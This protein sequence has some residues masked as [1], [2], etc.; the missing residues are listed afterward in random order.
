MATQQK[1]NGNGDMR[2]IR[3]GF[4]IFLASES[5]VIVTL[6]A[7]RFLTAGGNVGPYSQ[8]L[9]AIT[10]LFMLISGFA[11]RSGRTAITRGDNSAMQRRLKTGVWFGVLTVASVLLQWILFAHEGVAVTQPA[12]EAYYVLTGIWMLIALVSGFALYAAPIRGRRIGGY[13]T[14]NH[15]DVDAATYF[16][17][18]AAIGWIALYVVLYFL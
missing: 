3:A 4:G 15:W 5:V 7:A 11:A 18:F 6:I 17:S 16:W 2:A 1:T 13:T 12:A 9:G 8:W 14:D 10:T